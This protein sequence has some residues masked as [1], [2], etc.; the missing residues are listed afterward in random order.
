MAGPLEAMI[1]M[2]APRFARKES[3]ANVTALRDGV[4]GGGGGL[5][6]LLDAG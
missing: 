2:I 1:A 3:V 6:E 4:D 5:E